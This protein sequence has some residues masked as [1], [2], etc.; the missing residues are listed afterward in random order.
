MTRR[1][2]FIVFIVFIVA[3]IFLAAPSA[4]AQEP[5]GAGRTEVLAAL[6]GGGAV[7]MPPAAGE[8]G[9]TTNYLLGIAVTRNMNPWIGVN[10]DLGIVLG[11]HTAHELYGSAWRD[12]KTPN[13][14][15]AGG[16]LIVNPWRSD[17][18]IVPFLQGGVG[19]LRVFDGGAVHPTLSGGGGLRWFPAPHYGVRA[20]YSFIGIGNQDDP[21]LTSERAIRHAHRVS[22]SLVLTF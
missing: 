7:F 8:A 15:L 10:G 5:A 4:L 16:D 11:R 3:T 1:I 2:A 19:I 17:R 13:M 22:G 9:T 18:P 20:A 12:Q 14:L 6:F 21:A